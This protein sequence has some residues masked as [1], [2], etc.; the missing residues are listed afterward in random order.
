M[1]STQSRPT[2]CSSIML[3]G[4]HGLVVFSI[5]RKWFELSADGSKWHTQDEGL[6]SEQSLPDEPAYQ[7]PR[8]PACTKTLSFPIRLCTAS[9]RMALAGIA[10][11]ETCRRCCGEGPARSKR[12]LFNQSSGPG[13]YDAR[14][15]VSSALVANTEDGSER[16]L[17]CST[18]KDRR[19]ALSLRPPKSEQAM[20]CSM[21]T[22]VSALLSLGTGAKQLCG[23]HKRRC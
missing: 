8:R 11:A 19:R 17:P 14:I 15:R 7:R 20:Q 5:R 3:L 4:S 9:T 2:I 12:R 6:C 23:E 13:R 10:A 18:V 22:A 21:P 16:A 1:L